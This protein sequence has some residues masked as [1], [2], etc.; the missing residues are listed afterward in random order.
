MLTK[1]KISNGGGETT[2][3]L[4]SGDLHRGSNQCIWSELSKEVASNLSKSVVSLALPNGQEFACSGIALECVGN[5]TRF[6]T[7]ASLARALIGNRSDHDNL[8]VEVRL[9]RDV[10]TGFLGQY[11][12]DHEIAV[13]IVM[14][15][16]DVHVVLLN[17]PAKLEPAC[18]VVALGHGISGDV[19]ATDGILTDNSSGELKL[20]TCN[21]SKVY[22]GGALFDFGGNFLGMNF[23]RDSEGTFFLPARMVLHWLTRFTSLRRIKFP[24]HSDFFRAVRVGQRFTAEV[25]NSNSNQ[26]VHRDVPDMDQSEE[27]GYP[28][29]SISML[30]DG[31]ILINTFEDPFGD[32]C[33]EGVWR[34]LSETTSSIIH[35]NIVAL[36]SFNGE[37]RFSACTGFFIEWNGCST[38]LTS[39]SLVRKSGYENKIVENLRIEVLLPTKKRVEGTLQH[40][41]LHYN[42]ALVSVKGFHASHPAKI[43]H[44]WDD[45]CDVVAVGYCFKSGKLMAARG[46]QFGMPV[47]LDCKYLCYSTCKITKAG[48]GGPLLDFDGRFIGMN[49]YE[50]KVGTPFLLWR[51]IL[52]VLEHFKTDGSVAKV[53]HAGKPS[54]LPGWTMAEDCSVRPNSW[55]VPEPSWC[56]PDDPK[57]Q[58][59]GS[60]AVYMNGW[61]ELY[62]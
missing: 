60:L 24:V 35:E 6:L 57:I 34:E 42:V 62:V 20:S 17:N 55:P 23:F 25:R 45:D 44:L 48:I 37:T 36:A 19:M 38:V 16:L 30:N 22:E 7:S 3:L 53:D 50:K 18:K 4:I 9:G 21:I 61:K 11:D 59:T 14:S 12:L 32:E 46:E 27:L 49:F 26:E 51:E 1:K 43:Q 2:E 52:D 56:H 29:P 28:K 33:G 31:M 40:Y 58:S 47:T 8:K 15:V 10:I 54:C 39:A 41:D 5:V 13:V